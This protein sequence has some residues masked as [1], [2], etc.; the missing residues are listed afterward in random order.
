MED[1]GVKIIDKLQRDPKGRK[2]Y[3]R[4]A[5]MTNTQFN[6]QKAAIGQQKVPPRN[7]QTAKGVYRRPLTSK[8][9]AGYVIYNGQQSQQHSVRLAHDS[10]YPSTAQDSY[11]IKSAV[12]GQKDAVRPYTRKLA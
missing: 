4:F 9:P 12:F 3:N 5:N 1:I 11:R 2:A 6:Q 7:I 10:S 8:N